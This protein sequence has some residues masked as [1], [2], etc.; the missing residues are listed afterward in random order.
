MVTEKARFD[1]FAQSELNEAVAGTYKQAQ[2]SSG[3]VHPGGDFSDT[4]L[5]GCVG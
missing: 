1:D 5:G 2:K 4:M 3:L